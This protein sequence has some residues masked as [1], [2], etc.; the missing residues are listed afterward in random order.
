MI[1]NSYDFESGEG[2][3]MYWSGSIEEFAQVILYIII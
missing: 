2:F 1:E 3:G